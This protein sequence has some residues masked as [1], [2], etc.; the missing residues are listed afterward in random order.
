MYLQRKRR[1]AR[2]QTFAVNSEVVKDAKLGKV[3]PI[4]ISNDKTVEILP[5][6]IERDAVL[7]KITRQKK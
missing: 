2:K 7:E 1:K 4:V 5:A 3:A 6:V